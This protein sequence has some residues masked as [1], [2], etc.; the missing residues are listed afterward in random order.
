M[1]GPHA[2]RIRIAFGGQHRTVSLA[3][4]TRRVARVL[5]FLTPFGAAPQTGTFRV[6]VV[7][8]DRPV[9]IDGML[10]KRY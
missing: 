7:G 3:A 6:T 9:V 4:P 8:S 2:G 10:S 1:K 5:S